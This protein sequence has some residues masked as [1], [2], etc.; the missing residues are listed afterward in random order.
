[1][2]LPPS[3]FPIAYFSLRQL[4][5]HKH[6]LGRSTFRL[7]TRHI[8]FKTMALPRHLNSLLL[9]PPSSLIFAVSSS[10]TSPAPKLLR[11]LTPSNISAATSPYHYNYSL[12]PFLEPLYRFSTSCTESSQWTQRPSSRTL[13]A[14]PAPMSCR[15]MYASTALFRI[16]ALSNQLMK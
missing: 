10:I 3:G 13:M 11:I 1:M 8:F 16:Q 9:H 12:L 6:T 15:I 14:F 5:Y 2:L 4:P 7:S